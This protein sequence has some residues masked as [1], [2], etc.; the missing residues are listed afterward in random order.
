MVAIRVPSGLLKIL[1][2]M[3]NSAQKTFTMPSQITSMLD[4]PEGGTPLF[5]IFTMNTDS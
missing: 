5:I 4:R 2:T 1:K 3:L